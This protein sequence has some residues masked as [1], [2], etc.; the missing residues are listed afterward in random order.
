MA[1]VLIGKR[2]VELLDAVLSDI[3]E[4]EDAAVIIDAYTAQLTAV[5]ADAIAEHKA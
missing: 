5:I 3:M 4:P 2:A 1:N